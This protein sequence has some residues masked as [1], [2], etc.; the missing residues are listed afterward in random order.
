M[1]SAAG[2]NVRRFQFVNVHGVGDASGH[3]FV[4]NAREQ[5][6]ADGFT[7]TVAPTEDV[8]ADMLEQLLGPPM[9]RA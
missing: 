6:E 2:V 1:R 8:L 9:L 7:E 4:R 5:L 3:R